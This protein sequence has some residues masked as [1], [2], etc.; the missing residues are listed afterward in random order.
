MTELRIPVTKTNT[1]L[2]RTDSQLSRMTLN[3]T[4][5]SENSGMKPNQK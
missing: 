5:P 1:F 4:S 2:E 3:T